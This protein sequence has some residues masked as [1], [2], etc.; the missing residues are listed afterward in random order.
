MGG[1]GATVVRQTP[2]PTNQESTI[3]PFPK[4]NDITAEKIINQGS[5]GQR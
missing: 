3:P 1:P 2:A 5:A 4:K